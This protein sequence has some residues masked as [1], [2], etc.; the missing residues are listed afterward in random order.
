M[1]AKIKSAFSFFCQ[2]C[3]TMNR[4]QV[5]YAEKIFL[6]N[7]SE[8][9]VHLCY[10]HSV[11]FFTLGQ[12]KFFRKYNSRTIPYSQEMDEDVMIYLEEIERV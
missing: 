7:T 10:K 12:L 3:R 2:I 1:D 11:E 8:L 4:D 6:A 5:I 9:K